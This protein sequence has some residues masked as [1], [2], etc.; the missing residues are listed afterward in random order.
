[1]LFKTPSKP[2]SASVHVF[3]TP[4]AQAS[5]VQ[6]NFETPTIALKKWEIKG[7][8]SP[9]P[10]K[11]GK[12]IGILDGLPTHTPSP[13]KRKRDAQDAALMGELTDLSSKKA[14]VVAKGEE[15]ESEDD[16]IPLDPTTPSN[17]KR[18]YLIQTPVSKKL[19]LTAKRPESPD[20]FATPVFFKRHHY[21][22]EYKDNGSPVTPD[23]KRFMPPARH[24]KIK[25][26]SAM[27]QEMREAE[28]NEEDEGMDVL[29][30]M[31]QAE[32]NPAGS[33]SN[34]TNANSI[35]QAS[36]KLD[37]TKDVIL[38]DKV[39]ENTATTESVSQNVSGPTARVYKKKGA[40]RQTKRV[41]RKS[42]SNIPLI[43]Q[44]KVRSV[45][46][47]YWIV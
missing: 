6:P 11:N 47:T 40:K 19:N 4:K 7:Y 17:R 18:R 13:A 21:D 36:S 28:A 33:A 23:I 38:S 3:A 26:L 2:A 16:Y 24:A 30:E 20:P 1:M 43:P 14:K 9:T 32:L 10:Q 42:I 8:V 39:D 41:K 45:K 31:E 44:S 5:P 22:F 35:T 25:T 15:S 37:V 46:G 29:R 27:I 12:V 34:L